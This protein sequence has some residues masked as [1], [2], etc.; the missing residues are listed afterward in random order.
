MLPPLPLPPASAPHRD[1]LTATLAAASLHSCD[2]TAWSIS[3]APAPVELV[4][5]ALG[6]RTWEL[7]LR[8]LAVWGAFW[9]L[10]LFYAPVVALVQAPVNM[11]NLKKARACCLL[12]VCLVLLLLLVVVVVF[13]ACCASACG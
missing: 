11:D 8:Q 2:E 1:Q 9:C 3:P 5:S 12:G 7:G 13:V 4:W 10:V 6:L